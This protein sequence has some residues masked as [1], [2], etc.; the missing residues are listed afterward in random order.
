MIE[1]EN[2]TVSST[3]NINEAVV[4]VLQKQLHLTHTFSLKVALLCPWNK[5]INLM[6][7][8]H[9][10]IKMTSSRDISCFNNIPSNLKR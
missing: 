3:Y 7:W 8:E 6:L 5:N 4:I 2:C 1:I 9:K 10:I